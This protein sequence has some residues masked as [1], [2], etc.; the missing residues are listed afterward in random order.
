MV[1]AWLL[2][3]AEVGRRPEVF[4]RPLEPDEA[5][6]SVEVARTTRDRVQFRH[7]PWLDDPAW[8]TRTSAASHG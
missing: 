5:Q 4:G 8:F 7:F 3:V 1:Q 6:R 2:E